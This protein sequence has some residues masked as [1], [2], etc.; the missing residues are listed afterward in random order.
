MKD[1]VYVIIY[2]VINLVT[3]NKKKAMEAHYSVRVEIWAM[4]DGV[5]Y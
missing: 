2:K 4:Q 1:L 3:W 5:E